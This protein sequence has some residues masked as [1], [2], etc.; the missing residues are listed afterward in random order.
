MPKVLEFTNKLEKCN[1][2]AR[3]VIESGSILMCIGIE[4]ELNLAVHV[5]R[6]TAVLEQI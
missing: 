1:C 5:L 4:K 3:N 6:V 2:R